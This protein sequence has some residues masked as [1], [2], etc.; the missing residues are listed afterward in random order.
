VKYYIIAGEASG[1]LHGSNLIKALMALDSDAHIRCWG[2]DKMAGTGAELVEHYRNTAFMGFVEVLFNLRKIFKFISD[3]KSDILTFQPDVLILIDYPGFNIRI[4][5]WAKKQKMKVVYYI[6][7]QIWA[8]H[9]SR[10]HTL[11]KY[12]DRLLVILPF[13]PAFFEQYHYRATYV[14][15]PLLD[16]ISQFEPSETP[17]KTDKPL[18]ALLPGSRQQEI[19]Y[20][21]PVMLEA[22]RST[23][24][25]VALAGAPSI[26]DDIYLD[27]ITE[28][29]LNGKV[30]LYRNQT[31]D[32]LAKSDY[33]WVGSGTATLET[34]LFGVPQIV[35]YKGNPVSFAI[36]KK[37]VKIPYI[38]LVNLIAGEEVVKEL[39][40][41]N[42]TVL[43]ILQEMENLKRNKKVIKEKYKNLKDQLGNA[44][45][46]QSA[47]EEILHL[48]K[49]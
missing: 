4:A 17:A 11:G 5:E 7:P 35:C 49:G 28:A 32:I 20:I 27:M 16:A 40:Q 47:A 29:G 30:T 10:V 41:E 42:L 45:A 15:H 36:A 13:E 43:N 38:S 1:D 37:I 26:A 18:L 48:L 39:I 2:G 14:G 21:L 31:Y 6:T 12:T 44:G 34:A 46:S 8:W 3:C 33:A 23:E 22:C 9:K 19:R 24:A 25:D